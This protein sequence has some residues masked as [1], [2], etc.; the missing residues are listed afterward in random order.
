[1]LSQIYFK[2]QGNSEYKVIKASFLFTDWQ[3]PLINAELGFPG[4]SWSSYKISASA[5]FRLLEAREYS[6]GQHSSNLYFSLLGAGN[7]NRE[8]AVF[9]KLIIAVSNCR[10]L[11]KL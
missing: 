2:N 6:L 9:A 10:K 5:K 1:M 11:S 8:L 7:G 3:N 4:S